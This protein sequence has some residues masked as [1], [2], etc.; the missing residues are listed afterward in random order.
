[1]FTMDEKWKNGLP[2]ARSDRNWQSVSEKLNAFF[3]VYERSLLKSK[4]RV[5][6]H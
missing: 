6:K 4:K 5:Q 3:D 2:E 1:M